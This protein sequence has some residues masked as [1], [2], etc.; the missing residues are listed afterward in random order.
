M[1]LG[2]AVTHSATRYPDEIALFDDERA[3]TYRSLDERTSRFANMLISYWGLDRGDRVALLMSN[4]IEVSEV[5]FGCAKAGVVYVG[6]N[7][8]LG[9]AEYMDILANCE[10]RLIVTE[11]EFSEMASDL[12]VECDVPVVD[13]DDPS[14]TGYEALLGGASPNPPASLHTVGPA[15]DVCIVYTSGTTGRPKGVLYDHGAVLQ[16]ALAC[17]VEYELTHESRWIAVLPHNSCVQITMVPLT[18]VGGAIG[19]TE[20]RGFDGERFARSVEDHHATH[21][22]LVPTQLYR[23]L[24]QVRTP[25]QLRSIVTLGYGAAPMSPDR[26]GELVERYGPIFNQL[27]GMVEVSSIGT[28]LRKHDHAR[29]IASEPKLLASAGQC[30]YLID[31]RVTKEDG[32]DVTPGERGEVIFGGPYLMKGYYRDPDRTSEVLVDGWMHSGDIGAFDE[33]GY[34][35]IVDRKKDLIIRGGFNIMPSEVEN[36]L[37]SHPAVLEAAIVGVPDT[38]WGEALLGVVAFRAGREVEPQELTEWC[39]EA[40]LPSIKVP[41]RIEV[42]T[43]LPKNAVGKIAKREIRDRFWTDERKV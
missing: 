35:Y 5:L 9:Q 29:A 33:A 1:N 3:M 10:P 27:Y 11:A 14:P 21:S 19:F 43:A 6:L 2:L 25:K 22:Y 8:R 23:L 13:L 20:T 12:A 28:M 39:R 31:V 15:D 36:V 38:E 34:L 32:T 26:A 17:I 18:L 41:G 16:H 24:E 40:G 37:Y 30:S 4:R 7:F 42:M